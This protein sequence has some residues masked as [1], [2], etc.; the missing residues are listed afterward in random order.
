MTNSSV[1]TVP[2]EKLS[3]VFGEGPSQ[4][5]GGPGR[6]MNGIPRFELE[7]KRR[8]DGTYENVE[9][10]T[11]LTSGDPKAAPR[12]KVTDAIREKY[13]PWYEHWRAGLET[14]PTGTP[15]EMWPILKPAQ[16][17][18]LKAINIFTVEQLAEI[19]DNNL[20]R[21]PMGRTLKNQAAAW[22]QTKKEADGVEAARRE[23]QTL[24]D[25]MSVLE[26]QVKA[27]SAK[28]E[29]TQASEP[30]SEVQTPEP[31]QETVSDDPPDQ[32]HNFQPPKRGP[33][34]PKGSGR[35]QETETQAGGTDE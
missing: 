34:R 21:I 20:H 25:G 8:P 16:V 6:P 15:L 4:Q 14:S 24:K 30:V 35:K 13:K 11:I 32:S 26:E 17:H 23:N 2:P 28:L 5:F 22:L 9:Y 3:E 18:E 12:H 33:G 1:Q 10:V 31:P 7:A 27:L 19:A 29:E